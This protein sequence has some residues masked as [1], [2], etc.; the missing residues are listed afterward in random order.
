MPKNRSLGPQCLENSNLHTGVGYVVVTANDVRDTEI[1]I[2]HHRRQGIK[3]SAVFTHQHRI[4]HRGQI[5]GLRAPNKV[6]PMNLRALR[7]KRISF[8]IRQQETPVWL[9]SFSFKRSFL[10]VSE[11]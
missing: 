11:F 7:I 6:I 2:I 9:A 1:N 4:G 5:D 3:I 8:E 10:I